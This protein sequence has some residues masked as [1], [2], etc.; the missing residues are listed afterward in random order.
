MEQAPKGRELIAGVAASEGLGSLVMFGLGGIF[1]EVMKDVAAA[2]APLSLPEADELV[3]AIQGFEVLSGARGT[4]PVDLPALSEM[5]V[6]VSLLAAD[7]PEIVEMDLNPIFAY[8]LGQAPVA[9]DVR[10]KVQ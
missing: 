3:R 6:R 1:V 7:F 5:L 10:L 8:P 4:E 2:V 9:V